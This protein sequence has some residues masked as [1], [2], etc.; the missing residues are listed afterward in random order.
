MR[1]PSPV[2]E[3]K[4]VARKKMS[5]QPQAMTHSQSHKSLMPSRSPDGKSR[6]L[7]V[8][9]SLAKLKAVMSP[10]RAASA[11]KIRTNYRPDEGTMSKLSSI[12]EKKKRNHN[13]EASFDNSVE[14][15]KSFQ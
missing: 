10:N 3:Q 1:R 4:T 5:Q 15:S 2:K 9:N 14:A 7:T 6:P 11:M 12:K 13:F 8:A